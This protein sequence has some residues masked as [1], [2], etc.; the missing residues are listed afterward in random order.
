MFL[1]DP[2]VLYFSVHRFDS[3]GF[4]PGPSGSPKIIGN[5]D[6]VG[7]NVNIGWNSRGTDGFP[8]SY[9]D[10]DYLAAWDRVLLPMAYEVFVLLARS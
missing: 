2:R 3:G 1:S 5:G 6:G 7:K 4:Y 8:I 10:G 9:G